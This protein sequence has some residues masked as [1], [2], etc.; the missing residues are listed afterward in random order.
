MRHP[1]KTAITAALMAIPLPLFAAPQTTIWNTNQGPALPLRYIETTP[2]LRLTPHIANAETYAPLALFQH[3]YPSIPKPTVAPLRAEGNIEPSIASKSD[4]IGLLFRRGNL[5]PSYVQE[6]AYID[7]Y[8]NSREY[9]DIFNFPSIR[10]SLAM[11]RIGTGFGGGYQPLQFGF[12]PNAF[13][14]W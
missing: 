13:P 11:P 2:V 4:E 10:M 6:F 12:G 7:T 9:E 8:T 3:L 14:F 5:S 1:I